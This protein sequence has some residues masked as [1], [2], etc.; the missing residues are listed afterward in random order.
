MLIISVGII[1][2]NFVTAITAPTI[3]IALTG[4]EP[5]LDLP[6]RMSF[7][8]F[9]SHCW[10]TG[11]DQTHTLV[12]QLQLL[13]TNVK[14]WLDVDNLDDVGML[15]QSVK[16]SAVFI[17]FL[18]TG[19]FESANCRRELYTALAENKPIVVVREADE[20]KGGADIEIFKAE[21]RDACVETA[22]PAY[23]EYK[24]PTEVLARL[25]TEEPVVW[26]R[27]HDFQIESLKLVTLRML[28]HL[29][30]YLNNSDLLSMGLKI[31]GEMGEVGFQT[32]MK[33]LVCNENKGA[34]PVAVELMTASRENARA[35]EILVREAEQE[36]R[37]S[38]TLQ[39]DET[40]MLLYLNADTFQD[41]DDK[42]STIVRHAM[43]LNIRI[44]LVHEQDTRRGACAFRLLFDKTPKPLQLSPYRLF[45]TVAVPLYPSPEHRRLSLR[46]ILGSMGATSIK[47]ASSASCFQ[48][49][50]AGVS[51]RP[52]LTGPGALH[53]P[54]SL[55][56]APAPDVALDDP[57]AG[58]GSRMPVEIKRRPGSAK[59]GP[60]LFVCSKGCGFEGKF[61]AV[62]EHQLACI[63]ALAFDF[64]L[65]A[66]Q[67]APEDAHS[68][69]ACLEIIGAGPERQQ[70]GAKSSRRHLAKKPLVATS[71]ANRPIQEVDSLPV[72]YFL[73]P[74]RLTLS[75]L[76]SSTPKF[77][78]LNLRFAG[79]TWGGQ[80]RTTK[81]KTSRNQA[82]LRG[83]V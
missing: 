77:I 60:K 18:S 75:R 38:S 37:E 4:Y 48:W 83:E 72:V 81:R 29:P 64:D 25:F 61:Y 59:S 42:L 49:L 10:S 40:S 52:D 82:G 23:P 30:Y 78:F 36:L 63:E 65:P 14:I 80:N 70:G 33:L 46:L 57:V 19:Y 3:R 39:P 5:V 21:C 12:R 26:V 68:Q 2:I 67:H 69:H 28:Q 32:S 51:S 22:P 16:D 34:W 27:M 13:I 9:V 73:S 74:C 76:A 1:T 41:Q 62:L 55:V 45:D 50:W 79:V 6:M 58:K 17:I 66:S 44:V 56:D 35:V 43:D 20:T 15:E 24:G 11:Q 7:H 71:A 8:C 54:T 47:A 31:P 53:A